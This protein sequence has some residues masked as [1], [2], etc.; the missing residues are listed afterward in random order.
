[1]R[2]VLFFDGVRAYWFT[3]GGTEIRSRAAEPGRY[4]FTDEGIQLLS[5]RWNG[6]PIYWPDDLSNS[7][8]HLAH[9]LGADLVTNREEYQRLRGAEQ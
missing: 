5:G 7:G 1:M 9:V 6:S 3:P 4:V 8:E 2:T